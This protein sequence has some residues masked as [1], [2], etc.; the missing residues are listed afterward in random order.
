MAGDNIYHYFPLWKYILLQIKEQLGTHVEMA[1]TLTFVVDYCEV[2]VNIIFVCQKLF[3]R[4]NTKS[5][6]S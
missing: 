3:L 5:E 1:E 2:L 4:K 6:I